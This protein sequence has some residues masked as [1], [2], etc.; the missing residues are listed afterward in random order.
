MFTLV[1][2]KVGP[3]FLE[4]SSISNAL[5]QQPAVEIER[6]SHENLIHSYR[7][8]TSCMQKKPLKRYT[9]SIYGPAVIKWMALVSVQL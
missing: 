5:L 6:A 2:G 8:A 3:I 1:W 4:L 7:K 9:L